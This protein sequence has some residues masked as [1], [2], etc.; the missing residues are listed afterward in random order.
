VVKWKQLPWNKYRR[1]DRK[2][3]FMQKYRWHL[4]SLFLLICYAG[5]RATAAALTPDESAPRTISQLESSGQIQTG[6]SALALWWWKAMRQLHRWW[7]A[8]QNWLGSLFPETKPLSPHA[9]VSPMWI[10]VLFVSALVLVLIVAAVL[11]WRIWKNMPAPEPDGDL[12]DEELFLLPPEELRQRAGRFAAEGNYREALRYLYI[13]M[14]MLMD[15]RGVWHYDINRT[16]W[17]HIAQLSHEAKRMDL[18]VPLSDMTRRFDRVRYG[19][20]ACDGGDWERFQSKYG[21]LEA[22]LPSP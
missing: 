21:E 1:D 10:K 17:E 6:P 13:S 16:N 14:L 11:L 20:A 22:L 18:V 12:G 8:F 15:A 9:N 3:T 4:T 2:S 19:N 5:V 7:D